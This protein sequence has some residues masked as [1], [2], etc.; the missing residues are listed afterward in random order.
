MTAVLVLRWF[1]HE[2][3]MVF[4]TRGSAES[5]QRS[6]SFAAARMAVVLSTPVVLPGTDAGV[7]GTVAVG[8]PPV[9][10]EIVE[11][12]SWGGHY[13]IVMSPHFT[14]SWVHDLTDPEYLAS[15]VATDRANRL[16]VD[17]RKEADGAT[18]G[19]AGGSR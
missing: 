16:M 15:A 11:I 17:T 9:Y 2:H 5:A 13:E 10:G 4:K 8:F 1:S 3:T 6:L 19:F 12:D 14:G 7:V 18:L